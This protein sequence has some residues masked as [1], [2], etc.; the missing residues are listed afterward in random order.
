M[1]IALR[2]VGWGGVGAGPTDRVGPER[3]IQQDEGRG[4][5]V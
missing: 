1:N 2:V 5:E 3:K 4:T